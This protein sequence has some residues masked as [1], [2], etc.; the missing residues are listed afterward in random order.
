M[1]NTPSINIIF[2]V[3]RADYLDFDRNFVT[4]TLGIEPSISRG[5]AALKNGGFKP[6]QWCFTLENITAWSIQEALD[7]LETVFSGKQTK[8]LNLQQNL[9]L[10]SAVTIGIHCPSCDR[11]ELYISSESMEFWGRMK[12]AVG[13]DLYIDIGEDDD[14]STL[15]LNAVRDE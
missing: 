14:L 9:G 15:L 2:S 8:V 11:P 6:A 4:E 13:I 1:E 3:E 7:K 5:Y 10:E 12:T